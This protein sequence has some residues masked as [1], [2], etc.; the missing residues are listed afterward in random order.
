MNL[1]H[2][3]IVNNRVTY[4]VLF[5]LMVLGL[6]AYQDLPRDSM[7]PFVVR[8]ASI[9]TNYQGAG[10]ERIEELLTIP[11]EEVVQELPE[12][13]NFTSTSRTGVSIVTVSLFDD[14]PEEDL[15]A[16][17]D[18]LRRK[19]DILN[20]SLPSEASAPTLQ[21][22]DIG[23][24]YGI[25]VGLTSD[26]YSYHE[27]EE[28]AEDLRNQIIA[29][30]DASKVE[31]GGIIEERIY[32]DYDDEALA[33]YGLTANQLQGIISSTNIIIPAG[34][35]NL[36]D[37]RIVLEASGNLESVDDLKNMLIRLGNG[38][39]L[40]LDELANVY[41]SY[42]TPRSEI[43]TV[44]GQDALSI[45]VSMKDGANIIRLGEDIDQLLQD[46]NKTLPIGLEAHRIASQDHEVDRSVNDFV[47][48]VIQS[49]LIVLVVVLVFLGV[50]AGIVVASIVPSVIIV[51]F[52]LMSYVG[53]GLNQVTLAALIIALGL[54]VDNGIVMVESMME[55]IEEGESR[56]EAAVASCKEFFTPLLISSLTTSA[57]FLSFYLAESTL[58]EIMGNLFIVVS[59]ALLSSWVLA[60]TLIPLIG[61]ILLKPKA[62]ES[63]EKKEGGTIFARLLGPYERLLTW[64]LNHPVMILVIIIALFFTSLYGFTLLPF[65]FMPNS[66]R[67]L[68]TLEVELPLGTKI[69]R[70]QETINQIESYI[71]EELRVKPGSD[72]LGI[73]D[74]SS[75]VG[76]G[77]NSFDQGYTA[78]E[79]NSAYAYMIINTSEYAANQPMMDQ[80]DAFCQANVF[81]GKVSIKE[82]VQ[83]G[84]ASVP[85]QIR[86]M[87]DDAAVLNRASNAV[88]QQLI[89]IPGTKNVDDDWGPRIKK[90]FVKIDPA[91]LNNSG[92]TNQ[93]IAQSLS[94]VLSGKNVGSFREEDNT[95]PIVM[96]AGDNDEITFSELES[97][98]VFSQS[99]GTNIPLAQV[100]TID[101][102]WQY[103][104]ILRRNLKRVITVESFL[105]TGHTASEITNALTPWLEENQSKW[106]GI[107]YEMGGESESSNDAMGA[108]IAQLPI[109]M[110]L[111][112][113]LL[114]IQFNSMRKSSMIFSVIPLGMIGIVGG[115]LI[116]GSFFSFTA[117][118][119]I[120][121]LAGIV[122]NDA[123]VL[124]DKIQQQQA[125]GLDKRKAVE[126]GAKSR[127]QPIL[128]TTF[129]TSFGMLPLWFGGGLMWQPMAISIIFGLFFGTVILLLYIPVMY[130][131]LMRNE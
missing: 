49:I 3:A 77:P 55:R 44:N 111:M 11:I 56:F 66:E 19:L 94:T 9:V 10:P 87:G 17:W 18:R 91:R 61:S 100:A 53:V 122:I 128:L 16:I 85:V 5:V 76:V 64:S 104:K 90:L 108:V 79:Q 93:D 50:R 63:H 13:K 89:S 70:S 119:G 103:P 95:I 43:V 20:R 105:Q 38:T 14:V 60:F 21:D 109:S 34:E 131:L 98:S 25:F 45:Y 107:S 23:T 26:G 86:L 99:S 92:L 48:N 65:E 62:K 114:V 47:N 125:Q 36:G 118:L 28:Y 2:L 8:A 96:Q 74:W 127:L 72:T 106:K 24:V 69:E 116:T 22:E 67:N 101:V 115:L 51:T 6:I 126:I 41:R 129:T 40:P 75:Y 30:D 4:L 124:I 83:G 112:V 54:L 121:S 27:L 84:G 59:I 31:I 1:T 113:I 33:T 29:L 97:I 117:F 102:A 58:G 71:E 80:L 78:G 15:Q 32:I 37:E 57:A 110:F 7:P 73:A 46:Y 120:I 123:I 88:K 52:L 130:L 35:V 12:V 81:D 42:V 39:T 82:L 68:I